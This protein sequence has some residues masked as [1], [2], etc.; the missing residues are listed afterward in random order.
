MHHVAILHDIVLP[1]DA[2]AARLANRLLALE[3]VEVLDR[4]GLGADEPLL[5]VGMDDPGGLR[6]R[7]SLVDRPR[8]DFLLARGEVGLQSKE[9]IRATRDGGESGL[10][11]AERLKH[12]VA[13]R[14]REFREFTLDLGADHCHQ[15]PVTLGVFAHLPDE[16]ALAL[17]I[18]FIDIGDEEDA[19]GGDHPDLLEFDRLLWGW[20]DRPDGFRGV[21]CGK[22]TLQD[23]EARGGLLVAMRGGALGFVEEALGDLEVGEH[24]FRL[25]RVDVADGVDGTVDMGHIG[26]GEAADDMEDGVDLANVRKELVAQ[27][28]AFAGTLDE[29]GDV[30]ESES[31]RNHLLCLDVRLDFGEP[32]IRDADDADIGLDRAEGV[33]RGRGTRSG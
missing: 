11:H 25:D 16:G 33:V 23:R 21:E 8:A 4:E 3:I 9:V 26:I 12:F 28:L 7:E 18:G 20:V 13:V 17:R 2:H 6:R 1:F 31:R 14:L 24:Q 29:P 5:E 19:L 32:V 30:D 22:A 10:L 15:T 27:S